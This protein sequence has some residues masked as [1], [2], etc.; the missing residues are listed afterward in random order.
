MELYYVDGYA[1]ET[2]EEY[3]LALR[4]QKNIHTLMKKIDMQDRDSILVVYKRLASR[5]ILVTPIGLS[6][7]HSL[8]DTLVHEFHMEE[9]ELPM[10]SVAIKR[11]SKSSQDSDFTKEQLVR[12]NQKKTGT[13]LRLKIVIGGLL[14]IVI[15]MFILTAVNPDVGYIRSENKLVNKYSA[16][17]EELKAREA[18]V[19]EKEQKLGISPEEE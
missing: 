18:A 17:E 12:E 6:F 3:N 4:E 10:I 14:V 2:R 9:T 13:I 7:L 5:G 16:W 19:K 8:R 11:E 15:G 1:F